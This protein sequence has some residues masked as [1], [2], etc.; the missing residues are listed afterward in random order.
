MNATT[1]RG[2]AALILALATGLAAAAP[3]DPLA[4]LPKVR[5][6][7]QVEVLTGGIGAD[8]AAAMRAAS[9]AWPLALEFYREA[10]GRPAFTTGVKVSIADAQGR[11]VVQATSDG[12]FLFVKL[13]PGRYT[14]FATLGTETVERDVE[15]NPGKTARANLR[16][17]SAPATPPKR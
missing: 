5:L 17:G 8:E 11:P 9:S 13:P 15:V 4:A 12:P 3:G 7:G 16:W 1:S 10:A 2:V 6:A 14:V